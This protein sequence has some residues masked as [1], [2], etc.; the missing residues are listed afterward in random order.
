MA[1]SPAYVLSPSQGRRQGGAWGDLAPPVFVRS[2]NPISTRGGTLSPP[3]TTS[4]PGF[5]ELATALL[6]YSE[7]CSIQEE[8]EK[9]S[10]LGNTKK[11]AIAQWS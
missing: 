3:S 1:F 4:P 9:R 8:E 10:P 7:F 2:V 6:L 11:A 5:L